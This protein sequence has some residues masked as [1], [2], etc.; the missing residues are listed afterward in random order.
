VR[1][2][3][4]AIADCDEGP[5]H[6]LDRMTMMKSMGQTG[7]IALA[8]AGLMCAVLAWPA[9]SQ[10]AQ[11]GQQPAAETPAAQPPA[12]EAPT[13]ETPTA[14]T[15]ATDPAAGTGAQPAAPQFPPSH[16]AVAREVIEL[17]G[18]SNSLAELIPQVLNRT[19]LT[20]AR[21]RPELAK[22]LEEVSNTVLL[23][24]VP[25]R[26]EMLNIAA[27]TFAKEMTEEQLVAVATFF[28][29]PAGKVYVEKN[30]RILR[31]VLISMRPWTDQLNRVVFDRFREELKKKG[32]E[33]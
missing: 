7:L 1:Y 6:G 3:V 11:P 5:R 19:H 16:M 12:A 14:Q 28:K 13:A 20:I 30:Q 4:G 18:M 9:N 24:L 29:S 10:E 27:N 26:E 31:E 2:S 33:I 8:A 22:Q 21:Q 23:S 25:Q 32:V 17:S 15:P